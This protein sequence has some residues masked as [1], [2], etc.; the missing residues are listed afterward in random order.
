MARPASIILLGGG[1][2]RYVRSPR[3]RQGVEVDVVPDKG[4]LESETRGVMI[5]QGEM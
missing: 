1:P 2:P 4:F 5:S 3:G